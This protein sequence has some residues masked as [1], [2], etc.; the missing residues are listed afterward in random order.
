MTPAPT[1][2]VD[3]TL[4]QCVKLMAEEVST[5]LKRQIA[6]D[7][8]EIK[9]DL[10]DLVGWRPEME[11]RVND[12]QAA[13][14]RLQ[15]AHAPPAAAPGEPAAAHLAATPRSIGDGGLQGGG[16]CRG[17]SRAIWPRRRSNYLGAGAANRSD[18]GASSGHRC[19]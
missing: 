14:G 8:G 4:R 10:K 16:N 7:L 1:A 13:V 12:L 5:N 6:E 3:D 11:T 17:G 18:S 15:Q 2:V 19:D 9:L